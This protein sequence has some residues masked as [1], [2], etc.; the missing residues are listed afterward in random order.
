MHYKILEIEK[1]SSPKLEEDVFVGTLQTFQFDDSAIHAKPV[2][3]QICHQKD[4]GRSLNFQLHM[5]SFSA[6]SLNL[7]KR[8]LRKLFK[9]NPFEGQLERLKDG[10]SNDAIEGEEAI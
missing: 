4:F 2:V 8:S 6:Y 7:Q 9:T 1:E 3:L 10:M 5:R